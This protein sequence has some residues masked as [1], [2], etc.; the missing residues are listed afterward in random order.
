[1]RILQSFFILIA[2]SI[3]SIYAWSAPEKPTSP[4]AVQIYGK[5]E[6]VFPLF[7]GAGLGL[8][9][10][11]QFDFSVMYGLTPQPYYDVIGEV[12]ASFGN[13]SAYKDVVV[14]A[15]QN[16]S[17]IRAQGDYFFETSRTGWLAGGGF[18]Y[19]MANG[20]AGVDRV[21]TVATG[22]DYSGLRQALIAAGRNLEVDMDSKIMVIDLRGGYMW[23]LG[24]DF[25][26]KGTAGFAKVISSEVT[27]KSGLPGYDSTAYG[28]SQMRTAESDIQSIL[29]ENA[30]SPTIGV[31]VRYLF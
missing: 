5:A 25:T 27:L 21:L 6:T 3:F 19:L 29:N 28:N 2:L 14:A 12:A 23:D 9:V 7:V 10:L 20:K 31:E 13:K 17:L 16:N 15:F 30:F 4:S 11:E 24:N 18:S 22:R 8:Q 26:V 1:M